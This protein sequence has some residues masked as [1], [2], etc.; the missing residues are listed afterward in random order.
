MNVDKFGHHVHKRLRLS[1]VGEIKDN[2]LL[3]T[4]NGDFD[5]QSSRLKGV[6]IPVSPDD[7]VNKQYVDH[8]A[9]N[10]YD[11]IKLESMFQ[12]INSHISQLANQLRLNF[13]T[14]KEIDSMLSE[15][16]NDKGRNRK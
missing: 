13:Y 8:I 6:V 10:T 4:E 14:N 7:A 1:E 2:A 3:R 15:L 11:K 5:L 9:L 12:T 16:N